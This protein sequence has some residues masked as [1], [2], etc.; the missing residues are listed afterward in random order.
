MVRRSSPGM[1]VMSGSRAAPAEPWQPP[2]DSAP[3]AR[4]GDRTVQM[5]NFPN[6]WL[7]QG[8]ESLREKIQTLLERFGDIEGPPDVRMVFG[9]GAIAM[10]TF[11]WEANAQNA[12]QELHG[13]DRRTG[14]EKKIANDAPPKEFER[15]YVQKASQ[16]VSTPGATASSAQA[17]APQT[18]AAAPAMKKQGESPRFIRIS[19]LPAEWTAQAVEDLCCQYGEVIK[20]WIDIPGR[21]VVGFA[22][23][24]VATLAS[25]SLQ[26]QP[27]QNEVGFNKIT[28]ELLNFEPKPPRAVVQ[29]SAA[30]A[31][32]AAGG[33]KAESPAW[34]AAAA[35]SK[36]LAKLPAQLQPADTS[37]AAVGEREPSPRPAAAP[38]L[39]KAAVPESQPRAPRGGSGE[40]ASSNG[41]KVKLEALPPSAEQHAV[42]PAEEARAQPQPGQQPPQH[43]PT[44]RPSP[45]PQQQPP[46]KPPSQPLQAPLVIYVD[47]LLLDTTESGEQGHLSLAE[48]LRRGTGSIDGVA[49][50]EAELCDVIASR[51][52]GLKADVEGLKLVLL[53]GEGRRV[54]A[55][56]PRGAE[57]EAVALERGRLRFAVWPKSAFERSAAVDHLRKRLAA[58]VEGAIA[59]PP[60]PP[61]E[62]R[63]TDCSAQQAPTLSSSAAAIGESLQQLMQPLSDEDSSES[64]SLSDAETMSSG[65]GD[66][67]PAVEAPAN[68]TE[69]RTPCVCVRGFPPSWAE[70]EVRLIFVA[71]GGVAAVHFVCEDGNHRAAHVELKDPEEMAKAVEHLNNTQVGDGDIIKECTIHLELL[72]ASPKANK[73][74]VQRLLFV[75]ELPMPSR[76]NVPSTLQDREVF[77]E[78]LPVKDC[79]EEQIHGWLEGFGAVHEVYHIRDP[80]TGDATGR[81]YARFATHKEAATCIDAAAEDDVVAWWSESERAQRRAASAYNA[82]LHS[83]FGGV[84]DRIA[85]A[86]LAASKLK[87]VWML[88]EQYQPKDRGAPSAKAK[89]LHFCAECD[90]QEFSHLKEVLSNALKSFHLKVMRIAR[91]KDSE[92]HRGRDLRPAGRQAV[93]AS[94]VPPPAAMAPAHGPRQPPPHWGSGAPPA[95]AAPLPPHHSWYDWRP[96]PIPGVSRPVLGDPWF[97]PPPGQFYSLPQPLP[98]PGWAGPLPPHAV[99][100]PPGQWTGGA[101]PAPGLGGRSPSPPRR[102]TAARTGPSPASSRKRLRERA[103]PA[104]SAEGRPPKRIGR[105]SEPDGAG[106]RADRRSQPSRRRACPR[107]SSEASSTSVEEEPPFDD[108]QQQRLDEGLR[109]I[110]RGQEAA[111]NGLAGKA[112][113]KYC[114]ALPGLLAVVGQLGEDRPTLQQEWQKRINGYM[115]EAEKLKAE[116][117]VMAAATAATIRNGGGREQSRPTPAPAAIESRHSARAHHPSSR[118]SRAASGLPGTPAAVASP[119]LA[120]KPN[121]S[122]DTGETS[123]REFKRRL[124][125]GELLIQEA[126]ERED[127]GDLK[128]AYEKYCSGLQ[129]LLEALP[130]LAEDSQEANLLRTK[131]S[132]YLKEAE[133]LKELLEGPSASG[134][135]LAHD[136][137]P[138]PARG[139]KHANEV[140]RHSDQQHRRHRLPPEHRR[141]HRRHSKVASYSCDDGSDLRSRRHGATGSRG[142]ARPRR[143]GSHAVGAPRSHESSVR[144]SERVR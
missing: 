125:S 46:R 134:D 84:N 98:P 45:T 11:V 27:V 78:Q 128:D 64:D 30:G 116:A 59:P 73:G 25:D 130:T 40:A 76:P 117:A 77:L 83:A 8:E 81:G 22:S 74:V 87:E 103:E 110:R 68:A 119:T 62:P 58:L 123:S 143:L 26:D 99:G 114:R 20:C 90:E 39:P 21:F 13:K 12:I 51:L 111:Q 129:A 2:G 122:A 79:T 126:E 49:Q 69:P 63:G 6:S 144:L 67:P 18:E 17:G 29:P 96:P 3:M 140:S 136:P 24:E 57:K 86:L 106:V 139:A 105:P 32:G 121:F 53:A 91:S 54:A 44:Q 82:D 132:K 7:A 104:E 43:P 55:D 113:E 31:P 109:L 52:E 115:D 75:D 65:A 127:A 102:A 70:K 15:F 5:T 137:D 61:A 50:A 131:I 38:D 34:A 72:G 41:F 112:Y 66:R 97:G 10:A 92:D 138:V 1:A 80:F 23:S 71:F 141:R 19:D 56:L 37:A 42:E 88:S 48:R 108:E 135:D 60:S 100:P 124:K 85:A 94:H 28:C 16:S 89:Q 95:A 33:P 35:A 107:T 142:S 118:T 93:Q 120:H 9:G 14:V 36:R 4:V 47:D 101:L 133:R